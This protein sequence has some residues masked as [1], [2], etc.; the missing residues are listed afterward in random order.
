MQE[1]HVIVDHRF[2]FWEGA[3]F[4]AGLTFGPI[5]LLLMPLGAVLQIVFRVGRRRRKEPA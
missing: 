3:K 4:G 5:L 1:S 2:G